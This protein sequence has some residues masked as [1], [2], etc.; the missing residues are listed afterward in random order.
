MM[1]LIQEKKNLSELSTFRIG[2]PADYFAE[3][4]S[5]EKMR[6]ALVFSQRRKL[7]LMIVG[8]GSNCLFDDRG[9]KGIVILNKISFIEKKAPH[10]IRAGSGTSFS[11]LG[12][13]TAR[14]GLSGL[15]FA[16]GI[17][18]TVGGAVAM[19]AGADG[20]ETCET[21]CSV[22]FMDKEGNRRSWERGELSFSYR[23]SPFQKMKGAIISAEF[24]LSKSKEA[25]KRQIEI[26]QKRKQSQPLKE[27]SAGCIFRNPQGGHAGALIEKCGLKGKK[28]G[29]ASVST[30]H[31][32][33]IINAGQA[34]ADEVLSLIHFVEKEVQEKTGIKLQREVKYI[35]YE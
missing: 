21:L 29:G 17:P 20:K 22:D 10:I 27:K 6:E 2:G 34:T 28:I 7:N 32:N 24:S 25:R 8:K 1:S 5:P 30:L 16:S 9:F 18:G 31:A 13:Q 11:L 26:I 15:E 14:W 4:D 33:F 3:V 19:N 12:S 35:P 23:F